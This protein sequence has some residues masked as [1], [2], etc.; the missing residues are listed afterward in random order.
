MAEL[1]DLEPLGKFKR[2]THLSLLENPVARKDVG[3]P[4]YKDPVGLKGG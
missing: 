1:A 2:L 4:E 3:A